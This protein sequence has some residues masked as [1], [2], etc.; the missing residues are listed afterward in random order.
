MAQLSGNNILY[1]L[2]AMKEIVNKNHDNQLHGYQLR[3]SYYDYKIWYRAN[4]VMDC[5]IGYLEWHSNMY[6]KSYFYIK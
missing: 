2:T 1:T 3:I 6:Q 5:P 4:F